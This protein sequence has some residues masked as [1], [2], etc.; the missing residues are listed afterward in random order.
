MVQKGLRGLDWLVQRHEVKPIKGL[1]LKSRSLT[2]V[3]F[4]RNHFIL[5]WRFECYD[6]KA[7]SFHEKI[8]I[9][10]GK[11]VRP[12]VFFSFL[13]F[14]QCALDKRYFSG[15]REVQQRLGSD[16]FLK[17]QLHHPLFIL[18]ASIPCLAWSRSVLSLTESKANKTLLRSSRSLWFST[19]L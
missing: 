1:K 9:I 13:F 14:S 19:G 8:Q 11:N 2:P 7:D 6:G 10:W 5:E 17:S 18:Q 16:L 12:D 4:P 3:P 15:V